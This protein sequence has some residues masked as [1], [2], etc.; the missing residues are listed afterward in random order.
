MFE[1][2]K[3]LG[4]LLILVL[5]GSTTLGMQNQNPAEIQKWIE[6]L[7]DSDFS[8]RETAQKNLWA[9]GYKAEAVLKNAA[10][11]EDAEI[12]K[13]AIE[14]LEKFKWGIYPD[15]PIA[16]ID[17]VESYQG[18]TRDK[19]REYLEKLMD[20]KDHGARAII[21]ILQAIA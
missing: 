10:K 5:L 9:A 21:K 16:V 20:Q 11:G 17:L 4:L 3:Q 14:L 1:R 2:K 6:E 18:A 15:T 19:K 8:K 12:R 13:R 7:G